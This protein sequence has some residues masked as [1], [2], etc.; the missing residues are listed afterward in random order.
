MH[1]SAGREINA[2]AG[3]PGLQARKRHGFYQS[4]ER[5]VDETEGE[6]L[7]H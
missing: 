1:V 7:R 6:K 5:G 3:D 2:V 4:C